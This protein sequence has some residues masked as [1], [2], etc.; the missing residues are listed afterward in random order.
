MTVSLRLRFA[1]DKECTSEIIILI[2]P[3]YIL[4]FT[5]DSD[6]GEQNWVPF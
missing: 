6:T 4:W 1:L 2:I 5:W 3:T